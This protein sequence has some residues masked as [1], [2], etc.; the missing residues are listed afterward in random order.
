MNGVGPLALE[1][2]ASLSCLCDPLAQVHSVPYRQGANPY[3][4]AAERSTC[5]EATRSNASSHVLGHS[6]R[7][8]TGCL[9][10][11]MLVALPQGSARA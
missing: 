4:Q 1:G 8:T 5:R 9:A 11:M 2:S 6:Y 7:V 10:A 3:E